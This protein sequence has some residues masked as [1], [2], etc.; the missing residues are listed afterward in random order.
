MCF[1]VHIFTLQ[2]QND[3]ET[4]M[5]SLLFCYLQHDW[6]GVLQGVLGPSGVSV[7]LSSLVTVWTPEYFRQL[8]H[9]V[10][11]TSEQYIVYI[12]LCGLIVLSRYMAIVHYR[13]L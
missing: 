7:D 12:P 11:S 8:T 10:Q 5:P 6:L 4:I 1:K 3:T 9:L 2:T 13:A